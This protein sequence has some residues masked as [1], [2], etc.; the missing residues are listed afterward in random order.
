MDFIDF[1]KVLDLKA[2]N[3][4]RNIEGIGSLVSISKG[5]NTYRKHYIVPVYT[6]KGSPESSKIHGNYIN[7]FIAGDGAF[8]LRT[9]SNF[10]SMGYTNFSTC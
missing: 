8:Y 3:V 5:M 2:Q 6:E 1:I 9:K 7:G 10:G 4:H